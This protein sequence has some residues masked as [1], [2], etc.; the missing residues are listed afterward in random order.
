[1]MTEEKQLSDKLRY[2][3]HT[4]TFVAITVLTTAIVTST[5]NCAPLEAAPAA[6]LSPKSND[7][8]FD[9]DRAYGYLKAV[10]RFGKRPSG[11]TGMAQ[12]QGLIVE[13]FNRLG[14][15]VAY[16]SFDARHPLDGTPVRMNN[17]IVSWHPETRERVLIA[18]HYDTR[19]YPDADR[20]NPRGPFIGA[21][22]GAS[23]VAFLMEL[24]NQMKQIR[25]G[26]GVDFVFFDSEEF[27]FGDRGQ[28]FIGSEYFA[29]EY[30]DNPPA[31]RY[32]AGV[33]VDLIADR[34]L[35]I[36]RE[37]SSMRLAPD[38]TNA[39]W[40]AAREAG[41]REFIDSEKHEVNDDHLPLNKIAGIPT[42]DIIDFD[43]PAWHTTRDIPAQCSGE[44]L[45][46][47]ARVIVRWLETLPPAK[48]PM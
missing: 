42:C 19:P 12:Q 17:I 5:S 32:T 26:C 7:S 21:N 43:Y 10:C 13:H 46:K 16:Q 1:M 44:S 45:A 38:V 41:V 27:I 15:K 48:E 11:S 23:G 30:R 2:P 35:G 34:K 24:G 8:R 47:V 33:V 20:T 4:A 29:K 36:Y 25:A 3:Q 9:A 22:D 14:A 6:N 40:R 18:C 39:I 28:Y 37:K 31:H